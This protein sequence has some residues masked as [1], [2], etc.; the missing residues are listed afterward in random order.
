MWRGD[1]DG[2]ELKGGCVLFCTYALLVGDERY[3]Q[4]QAWSAVLL[5]S[6]FMFHVSGFGFGLATNN[7]EMLLLHAHCALKVKDGTHCT[8]GSNLAFLLST[9]TF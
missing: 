1:F 3:E 6:G 2:A 8:C 4:L 7:W 9:S 5:V